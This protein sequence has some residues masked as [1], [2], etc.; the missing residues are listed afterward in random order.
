MTRGAATR[1]GG[2]L[3]P[4]GPGGAGARVRPDESTVYRGWTRLTTD[5]HGWIPDPAGDG[6]R[7][8]WGL[9]CA[10]TR[11]LSGVSVLIDGRPPEPALS[12]NVAA[13]AWFGTFRA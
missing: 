13:H 11:L 10:N 2:P 7:R 12:G 3:D 4:R 9:F 8:A 1:R 6:S 5:P